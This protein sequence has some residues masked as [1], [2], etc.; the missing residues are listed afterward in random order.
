M[1]HTILEDCMFFSSARPCL[2][3]LHWKGVERLVGCVGTFDTLTQCLLHPLP[4]LP[5]RVSD[6][7]SGPKTCKMTVIYSFKHKLFNCANLKFST[8]VALPLA[9]Y[10][11]RCIFICL[12]FSCCAPEVFETF[13]TPS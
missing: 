9:G 13:H 11:F 8:S 10:P 12:L 6:Y 3:L 5:G 7:F 1:K 2:S 4:F